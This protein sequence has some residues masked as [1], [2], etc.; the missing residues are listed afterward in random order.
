MSNDNRIIHPVEKIIE[1]TKENTSLYERMMGNEKEKVYV[2]I[3]ANNL[4]ND[5]KG[6][7]SW[8]LE[9]DSKGYEEYNS[10]VNDYVT[11]KKEYYNVSEIK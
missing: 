7:L 6:V 3:Y 2:V 4:A 1:L 9:L 8:D 10:A 11:S 5:G